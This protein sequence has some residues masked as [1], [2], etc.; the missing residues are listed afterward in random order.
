MSDDKADEILALAHADETSSLK[1]V[2][3]RIRHGVQSLHEL[4]SKWYADT[5]HGQ[6]EYAIFLYRRIKPGRMSDVM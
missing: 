1:L 2:N 6:F 3:P 4:Q 5:Q